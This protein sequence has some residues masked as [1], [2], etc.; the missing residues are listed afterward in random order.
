M[1]SYDDD[2]SSDYENVKNEIEPNDH[3]LSIENV[4]SLDTQ[5][6]NDSTFQNSRISLENSLKLI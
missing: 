5:I 4:V 2:D 6:F 3:Q 1:S